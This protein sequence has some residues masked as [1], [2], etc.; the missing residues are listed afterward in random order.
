MDEPFGAVDS[1]TRAQ[2]QTEIKE[3]HRKTGVTIVFVTHDISEALYPGTRVLVLDKGEIQQY[4]TPENIIDSP[5][6][7]F[8]KALVEKSRRGI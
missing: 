4:D 1:I 2:L 6:N 8:V 3:I 7:Q 5:R